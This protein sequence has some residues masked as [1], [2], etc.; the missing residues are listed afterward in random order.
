[1]NSGEEHLN[2]AFIFKKKWLHTH[3]RTHTRSCVLCASWCFSIS[4]LQAS[5]AFLVSDVDHHRG[6]V[7]WEPPADCILCHISHRV[8]FMTGSW[9]RWFSLLSFQRCDCCSLRSL[10]KRDNWL[11]PAYPPDGHITN[12]SDSTTQQ[13][14][15]L[16]L[17]T[18]WIVFLVCNPPESFICDGV[19][20]GW[21]KRTLSR[22]PV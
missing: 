3:T 12:G 5:V 7:C 6:C 20:V 10:I 1:M 15:T 22:C 14:V 8:L 21:N 11:T 2:A 16:A 17:W 18:F 4:E 9:N 19:A 13:P